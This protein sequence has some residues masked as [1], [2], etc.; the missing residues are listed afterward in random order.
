MYRSFSLLL[1]FLCSEVQAA[2]L[3]RLRSRLDPNP[4]PSCGEGAEEA[5]GMVQELILTLQALGLPR[6][7][8][9]TPACQL[10]RD[11]DAKVARVPSTP[12]PPHLPRRGRAPSPK[13]APGGVPP[14]LMFFISRIVTAILG[15]MAGVLRVIGN[16]GSRRSRSDFSEVNSSFL[17]LPSDLRAAAFPAPRVPA[18]PPQPPTG[19]TQMGKVVYGCK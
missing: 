18:A 7:T 5:S 10:L 16:W 8:R 11:L 19:R 12:G 4:E 13:E 3:L 1:G 2:R 17:L 14:P 6:P 9:G 15:S